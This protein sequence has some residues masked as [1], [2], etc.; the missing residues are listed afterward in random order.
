RHRLPGR[1]GTTRH[2]TL[3]APFIRHALVLTARE[4]QILRMVEMGLSNREI[5]ERLC[6]A[7]HTVKNHMHS[8]LTKLGVSSRGEAAALCRM[9]G[10][11]DADQWTRQGLV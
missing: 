1:S 5:A 10:I 2:H 3:A 6:I 7:V 4:T 8:L 9:N 11:A